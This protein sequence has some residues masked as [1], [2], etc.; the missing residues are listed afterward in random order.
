MKRRLA[1][2][3]CAVLIVGASITAR[4][5]SLP[6]IQGG[7]AGIELC[8]QSLCGAAIFTGI[9]SGQ[10][11]IVRH[12][13]GSITVAVTHEDL[14]DSGQTAGVTGGVWQIKLL[15]GRKIAGVITGGSLHNN[16]NDTFHVIADMAIT[17]GGIGTTTFEG[18]LSHQTFPPTI[19][20]VISQ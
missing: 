10:V 13:F 12:A 5:S 11:G 7:V 1:F 8:P 14:P 20:G 3:A 15:G 9:F 19:G 17:S 18:T 6:V 4:A 2:V 16:G